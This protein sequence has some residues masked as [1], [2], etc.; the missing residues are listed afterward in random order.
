M[1]PTAMPTTENTQSNKIETRLFINNEF[2]ESIEGEKF[3]VFNP[4]NEE[5]VASVYEALSGDVDKAVDAAEAALP[6]WSE[7]GAFARS[8]YYYKLA[9]LLEA[10]GPELAELEAKETG[11]VASMY[12]KSHLPLTLDSDVVLTISSGAYHGCFG[13]ETICWPCFGH[14]RWYFS[15]HSWAR[16]YGHSPALWCLWCNCAMEYSCPR[17][18]HEDVSGS[19]YWKYTCGQIV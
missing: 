12:S 13:S 1:S 10:A 18:G 19:G 14:P 8:A 4:Y 15:G 9:D 6:A 3:D 7:L 2:V 5:K 11:K 17:C 16:Q